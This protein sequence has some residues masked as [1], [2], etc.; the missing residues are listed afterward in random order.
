MIAGHAFQ[1][2][3]VLAIAGDPVSHLCAVSAGKVRQG[4]DHQ[5]VHRLAVAWIRPRHGQEHARLT[6]ALPFANGGAVARREGIRDRVRDHKHAFIRQTRLGSD[7]SLGV[8]AD[9][10]N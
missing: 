4:P 6:K 3:Q 1:P 7:P 10:Q 2:R 5:V 8:A 9:A